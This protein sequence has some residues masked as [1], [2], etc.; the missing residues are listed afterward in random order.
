MASTGEP[1]R[2]LSAEDIYS[3]NA[4]LIRSF[5]GWLQTY[6]NL[7]QNV[8][9]NSLLATLQH[10][11]FGVELYPTL[12]DKVAALAWHIVTDHPFHDTNKRTGLEAAIELL[13]L[14]GY[15]T[16]FESRDLVE[17]VLKVANGTIEYHE[18]RNWIATN[19]SV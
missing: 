1:V 12:V 7:R 4:D 14:N 9:I 8:D 6:P 11:I 15:S 13:Q 3:I 2:F 17:T 19:A 10:P 5:G 16:H 18:F